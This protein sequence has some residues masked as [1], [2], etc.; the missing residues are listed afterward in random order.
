MNIDFVIA[1]SLLQDIEFSVRL[2]S[3]M[4]ASFLT[5]HWKSRFR[6]F[7]KKARSVNH[8]EVTLICE[9]IQNEEKNFFVRLTQI[10]NLRKGIPS[11]VNKKSVIFENNVICTCVDLMNQCSGYVKEKL[12]P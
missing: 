2:I 1:K 12:R 8:D 4:N 9:T 11:F 5:N 3:P 10:G 6:L 7:N